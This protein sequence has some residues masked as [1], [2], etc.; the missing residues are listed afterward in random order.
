VVVDIHVLLLNIALVELLLLLG[1]L[2]K[3]LH[4]LNLHIVSV[5]HCA[6]QQGRIIIFSEVMLVFNDPFLI[7]QALPLV[8]LVH[9]RLLPSSVVIEVHTSR[10]G[11]AGFAITLGSKLDAGLKVAVFVLGDELAFE[12]G[13]GRSIG[14]K[15]ESFVLGRECRET[16]GGLGREDALLYKNGC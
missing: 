3:L 2:V 8:F 12:K 16:L 15:L 9:A 1:V 14:G 11:Y 10:T 6:A 7:E 4:T 13:C 5:L